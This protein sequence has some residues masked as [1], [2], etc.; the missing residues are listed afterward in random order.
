MSARDL[1]ELDEPIVV[2]MPIF[3]PGDWANYDGR[4]YRIKHTVISKRE[5]FV[6]LEGIQ[7]PVPAH[8]LQVPWTQMSV[9]PRRSFAATVRSRQL[10][11]SPSGSQS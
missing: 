7:E 9:R 6:H 3:K 2:T 10:A 4:S 5:L 8:R 11:A 1:M